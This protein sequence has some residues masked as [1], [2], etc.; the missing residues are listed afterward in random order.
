LPAP[1]AAVAVLLEDE[2]L[3]AQFRLLSH[4]HG[5]L[6]GIFQFANIARP[7]LLLQLVHGGG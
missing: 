5:A 1:L 6:H 7:G 3:F 4:H 2:V